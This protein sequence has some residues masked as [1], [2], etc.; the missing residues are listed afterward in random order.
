[1]LNYDTV[2]I[3]FVFFVSVLHICWTCAFACTSVFNMH[4]YCYFLIC[5]SYGCD[6]VHWIWYTECCINSFN[7]LV[8]QMVQ[9]FLHLCKV[10]S[11]LLVNSRF[12]CLICYKVKFICLPR[13]QICSHLAIVP[14]RSL[15]C[16]LLLPWDFRIISTPL[17]SCCAHLWPFQKYCDR[18]N[19]IS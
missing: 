14:R 4:K 2:F 13:K 17:S 8:S 3:F 19:G 16:E 6:N 15:Y 5:Q 12:I 11:R 9:W 7:W 1:M 10:M 18:V